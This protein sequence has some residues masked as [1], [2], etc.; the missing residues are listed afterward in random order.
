MNQPTLDHL[1]IDS[2]KLGRF[3]TVIYD[4]DTTPLDMVIITIIAAT[5]CTV[6]EAT[7]EAWE[8]QAYG[9]APIHFATQTEC[10]LVATKMLSIGVHANVQP[11]W[12]E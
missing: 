10:Q 11:E 9:K 7:I 3:M 6:E 4:N 8:A 12:E 1:P 2:T 5:G